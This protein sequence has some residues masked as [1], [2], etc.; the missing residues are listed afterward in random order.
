MGHQRVLRYTVLVGPEPTKVPGGTPVLFH[1]AP[2]HRTPGLEHLLEVWFVRTLPDS[3]PADDRVDED[4]VQWVYPAATGQWV[5]PSW[6]HVLS[7]VD[8][9]TGG[10]WHLFRVPGEEVEGGEFREPQPH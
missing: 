9:Y 3:W 7:M 6:T 1:R 5:P 10:V 8:E 2:N 4:D